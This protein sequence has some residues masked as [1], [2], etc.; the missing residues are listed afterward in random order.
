MEI[1]TNEDLAFYERAKA[2]ALRRGISAEC[3][4]WLEKGQIKELK[5]F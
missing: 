5:K 1:L 4:N 2:E 3:L